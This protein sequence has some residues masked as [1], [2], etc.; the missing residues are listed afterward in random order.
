MTAV[1]IAVVSTIVVV[2]ETWIVAA[3]AM[4][5]AAEVVLATAVCAIM[6]IHGHTMVT[7]EAAR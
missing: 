1:E 7:T 4:E 3:E 6:L 2:M 5:A